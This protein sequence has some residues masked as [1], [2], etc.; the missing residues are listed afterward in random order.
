[1]LRKE[2]SPRS[3][4][5]DAIT[6]RRVFC[7]PDGCV[8]SGLSRGH[9]AATLATVA[10]TPCRSTTPRCH[11]KEIHAPQR[12][13][14][15]PAVSA[16]ASRVSARPPLL[17]RAEPIGT[18]RGRGWRG[19]ERIQRPSTVAASQGRL[20]RPTAGL[21][22]GYSKRGEHMPASSAKPS[23]RQRRLQR[24]TQQLTREFSR[25]ASKPPI[26]PVDRWRHQQHLPPLPAQPKQPTYLDH[27]FADV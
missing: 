14:V 15:V 18:R 21:N 3:A 16:R 11:Q 20:R 22:R 8:A 5:E 26:T 10:L 27:L 25:I 17:E 7:I 24:L 13:A 23:K 6:P 4:R 9:P 19:K 1:M 2:T 12:C